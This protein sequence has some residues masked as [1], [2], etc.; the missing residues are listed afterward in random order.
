M[1]RCDV[2]IV[3]SGHD[4]AD[5]RL[6]REVAALRRAGL[7]VEV[8]GLGDPSGA[9]P[10]AV[11]RT[12]ARRG[13]GPRVLMAATLPWAA[14]GR[15]LICLDPDLI[16]SAMLRRLTGRVRVVVDVHEDYQALLS[17]R[18][19]ARGVLGST[20]R[21]LVWSATRLAA[22]ADVTVVADEHV[23]PQFARRRLVVRNVPDPAMLPPLGERE[24]GPRAIYI[25]DVRTTRG[26]MTML[27]ALE[28]A[29]EWSLDVVGPVAPADRAA[30]TEWRA[31][32]AAADRARFHGRLEPRQAWALAQ[33]AWVGLALLDDTPA[34][35][36]AVPT[37]LYEY[38]ACGLAVISTPLPR[39]AEILADA[40]AGA[41]ARTPE[42][43]AAVLRAWAADPQEVDR[44]SERALA[45]SRAQE[46]AE[47]P[48]ET[49]ALVVCELGRA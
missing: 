2:S 39:M 14:R 8:L 1:R 21:M 41:T 47:S 43:V 36:A 23:P 32:S 15:T 9:P 29:P 10:G 3:T 40:G 26:L 48:Y 28:R 33:G 20:A 4:V 6:H 35:A 12:R 11:A 7:A 44:L 19:W 30:L 46:R 16:P 24:A 22:R 34:F 42:E 31:R 27:E 25:G 5:A 49:L 45:W 38:L 37:K 17:D 18:P 13:I